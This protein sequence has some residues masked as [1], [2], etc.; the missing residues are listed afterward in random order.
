MKNI[1]LAI[2]IAALAICTGHLLTHTPNTKSAARFVVV[3]SGW[4][5]T[6][7]EAIRDAKLKGFVE[8]VDVQAR[9]YHFQVSSTKRKG[10]DFLI[11]MR[12]SCE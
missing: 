7:E 9:T 11:K 10:G 3:E 4:K 12:V 8:L 1:T 6:R 5:E 2:L